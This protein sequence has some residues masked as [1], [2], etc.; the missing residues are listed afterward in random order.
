MKNFNEI[1]N[2]GKI[3]FPVRVIKEIQKLTDNNDHNSARVLVTKT[4]KNKKMLK[5]YEAIQ[6][7]HD[8]FGSVPPELSKMR[9]GLDKTLFSLLKHNYSNGT[10]IYMSF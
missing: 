6:D 4:M 3:E 5:A 2:E 9:N 8:Y 1:L 10:D 7:L